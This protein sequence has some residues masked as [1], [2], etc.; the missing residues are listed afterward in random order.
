MVKLSLFKCLWSKKKCGFQAS[1]SDR[2]PHIGL[3]YDILEVAYG[4]NTCFAEYQMTSWLAL[5]SWFREV[6]TDLERFSSN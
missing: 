4:N 2:R 5:P 1:L 6:S 3:L